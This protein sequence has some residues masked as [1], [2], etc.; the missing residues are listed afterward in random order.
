M[1]RYRRFAWKFRASYGHN[2]FEKL[3]IEWMVVTSYFQWG[4]NE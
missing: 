3:V 2:S 4:L 1:G